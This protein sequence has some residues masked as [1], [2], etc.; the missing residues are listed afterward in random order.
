MKTKFLLL[1]T[2]LT[3]SIVGF[4][5]PSNERTNK[6]AP[7]TIVPTLT[8]AAPADIVYGT[9]LT[10]AQLNASTSVEGTFAYTPNLGIVMDAGNSQ[11][12][13][14]IF[15][16]KDL[17]TYS[18]ARL[19]VKINVL[20]ANLDF[21]LPKPADIVYGTVLTTAQFAVTAPDLGYFEYNPALNTT[22]DAG[23]NQTLSVTFKP[24][25][26]KNYNDRTKYTTINVLKKTP[27]ISW[28]QPLNFTYGHKLSSLELNAS[29]PR[30]IAGTFTYTPASGTLLLAGDH[31]A[32]KVVF[33]PNEAAR[34]NTVEKTVY[35][36]VSKAVPSL[37]WTD[38]NPIVY[39]TPLDKDMLNGIADMDGTVTFDPPLGTIVDAGEQQTLSMHF[40]PIDLL[41]YEITSQTV[42]ISIAK[43]DQTVSMDEVATL[44]YNTTVPLT[45]K[46]F[47]D[48]VFTV[49]SG[50][51]TISSPGQLTANSGIGSCIVRAS[52]TGDK[53]HKGAFAERTVQF[54]KAAQTISFAAIE[55]HQTADQPFVLLASSSSG[56]P[57]SFANEN[58]S[59]AS[60]SGSTV[61][62]L[63]AGNTTIEAT[64]AGDDNYLP[65][66]SVSRS[67][68]ISQTPNA[69]RDLV[70]LGLKVFPN[71]FTDQV[72]VQLPSGTKCT[73]N[74]MD[75]N[76]QTLR[77]F[78]LKDTKNMINLS[79][80][81]KGI[82]LLQTSIDGQRT[83]F[84]LVK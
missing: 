18:Q 14:V 59:V 62:V 34:Y 31:Q 17:S 58:T 38:P 40:V 16:P 37:T 56:L 35:I 32:L 55:N 44:T 1:F 36:N 78:E 71:P 84:K 76:G 13:L 60:L 73:A 4:G 9:A 7:T 80:L 63:A 50:K 22:L 20:K 79:F 66:A 48:F 23:E 61:T 42:H 19:T 25:N 49:Q 69:I 65:A 21:E 24:S 30:D 26:S 70:A 29:V 74:L 15:T 45:A 72:F 3:A 43:A 27:I 8:W 39:G 6:P 67:F 83:N 54:K 68:S 5:L 11:D 51:A 33:T 41:N 77:L 53:N 28:T 82:Y 81:P 57:V 10:T 52:T 46:G 64:Q 12:L 75:A 2:L 47:G